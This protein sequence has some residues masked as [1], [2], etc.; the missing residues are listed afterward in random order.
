MT[1]SRRGFLAGILALGAAPAIVHNPMKVWVPNTELIKGDF[2]VIE[3]FQVIADEYVPVPAQNSTIQAFSAAL[4][5]E[6]ALATKSLISATEYQFL[7]VKEAR[8]DGL[9]YVPNNPYL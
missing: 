3:T 9:I 8:A 2:G 6:V 5:A 4:Y 1:V 7:V